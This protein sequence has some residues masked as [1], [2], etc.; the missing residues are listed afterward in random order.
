MA[1]RNPTPRRWLSRLHFLVRFLGLTGLLVVLVGGYLVYV[2]E[3]S[4]PA[5][6]N[7]A[8]QESETLPE[9]GQRYLDAAESALTGTLGEGIQIAAYL[10]LGGI[11]AA[12]LAALVEGVVALRVA[13]G[14]RS[15]AGR[16]ISALPSRPSCKTIYATFA[17]KRP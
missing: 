16:A 7:L 13:A 12:I 4:T 11:A 1:L 3:A 10:L 8:R 15:A 17:A 9:L 5:L 14:H 2:L 6:A